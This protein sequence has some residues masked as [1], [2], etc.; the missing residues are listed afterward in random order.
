KLDSAE[1]RTHDHDNVRKDLEGRETDNDQD[2]DVT[3]KTLIDTKVMVT[4]NTMKYDDAV[5]KFRVLESDLERTYE[6]LT[7][8]TSKVDGLENEASQVNTNLKNLESRD[9]EASERETSMEEQM[10]F[11]AAQLKD[12][13][14]RAEAA[15]RDG[16]KL[17]RLRDTIVGSIELEQKK[18]EATHMELEDTMGDLLKI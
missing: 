8:A 3:E 17:E 11:L 5:N 9:E 6:R 12:T 4:E 13:V 16:G 2:L 7:G 10:K 14:Q 15:E 1:G 18:L